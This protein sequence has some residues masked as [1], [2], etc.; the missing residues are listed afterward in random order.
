MELP[1]WGVVMTVDEPSQLVLANVAY[2]LGTGASEAHVYVD[3]PGD[4]VVAVLEGL[5]GVTV[6]TC[7]EAHWARLG[8]GRE[9]SQTKRQAANATQAYGSCE[10]DW[11]LHLDADEFLVQRDYDLREE[12]QHIPRGPGYLHVPNWE[13][14]YRAG[15]APTGLFDG[16]FRIPY[17]GRDIYESHLFGELTPF[18]VGGV[19]G[20]AVGKG[21]VPTRE[22]CVMGIH[23]PRRGSRARENKLPPIHSNTA[24]L[25]HFDGMTPLHWIMKILRYGLYGAA[26][27]G[28]LSADH[29]RNQIQ[30]ALEQC[31]SI[32]DLYEFHDRLKRLTEAEAARLDVLGL[33]T[34]VT[35]DPTPAI[36][37]V[38]GDVPDLSVAAFDAGLVDR[39]TVMLDALESG[40]A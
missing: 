36:R 15:V 12:L 18:L 17:S 14:V 21:I 26:T 28:S 11:L 34:D 38:L 31:R 24:V 32:A 22:N 4:P 30:F 2:H 16:T 7:D 20:H 35:F 9:D 5:P 6:T 10:V 3:K 40:A 1:T 8:S 33:H 23:G 13:R 27:L 19:T 29:R 25:A 37:A 39:F